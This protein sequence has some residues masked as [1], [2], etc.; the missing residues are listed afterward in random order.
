MTLF[1]SDVKDSEKATKSANENMTYS[2]FASSSFNVSLGRLTCFLNNFSRSACAFLILRCWLSRLAMASDSFCWSCFS[3][4]SDDAIDSADDGIVCLFP[5]SNRSLAKTISLSL[6]C[7]FVCLWI[8]FPNFVA[9]VVEIKSLLILV[10]GVANARTFE[11]LWLWSLC[12]YL[13][14][15]CK[16][17]N[18]L[19]D[20]RW[21]STY[22]CPL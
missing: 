11:N 3:N 1:A 4:S 16:R 2:I 7:R 6:D 20:S 8:V 9:G 19:Y 12:T 21:P 22:G 5:S 15:I 14:G 13:R 10:C 17:G 18:D